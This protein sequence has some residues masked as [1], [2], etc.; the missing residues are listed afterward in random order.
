MKNELTSSKAEQ[1][2]KPQAFLSYAH[3]DDEDPSKGHVERFYRDLQA[4]LNDLPGEPIKI[5]L[6]RDGLAFGAHWPSDLSDRL[7]NAQFLIPLLSP[8][9]FSSQ[10]CQKEALEFLD[11]EAETGRKDLILPIYI[12]TTNY[13]ED[14]KRMRGNTLAKK[15][16]ERQR[17]DFRKIFGQRSSTKGRKEKISQLAKEI[18][19]AASKRIKKDPGITKS[20]QPGETE[21]SNI[22]PKNRNYVLFYSIISLLIFSAFIY[23]FYYHQNEKEYIVSSGTDTGAYYK[24]AN[25]LI[26]FTEECRFLLKNEKTSGSARNLNNV[27]T[28]DD[29]LFGIVQSD[30]MHR[31]RDNNLYRDNISYIFSLYDEIIHLV[32]KDDVENIDDLA[33]K[34]INIGIENSG[35]AGTASIILKRLNQNNK[36]LSNNKIETKSIDEKRKGYDVVFE[37]LKAD[38]ISGF[39]YVARAPA[40]FLSNLKNKNLKILE[41][42]NE[43]INEDLGQDDYEYEEKMIDV[44]SD[45]TK[46]MIKMLSVQAILVTKKI[47]NGVGCEIIED[48]T[49][50]I[51]KSEISEPDVPK[52]WNKLNTE[53]EVQ[54]WE[55]SKCAR[56]AL[57]EK[58]L[59][60]KRCNPPSCKEGSIY[61]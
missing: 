27:A 15:L 28:N 58:E 59:V 20:E 47:E 37:Q 24:V 31:L 61:C 1:E 39:F 16:S 51:G 29:H 56:S 50:L 40:E 7:R 46:E 14:K 10:Q 12:A 42:D 26:K 35:T 21:K 53:L 44:Y 9:Y 11:Y 45:D 8:R 25:D 23:I 49:N 22:Y 32:V 4:A 33:G 52:V 19:D 55:R 48:V 54:D 3:L 41:I 43:Y 30:I 5:F 6:D 2:S 60:L 34:T 36:R 17:K 38:E 13:V 57:E 18:H